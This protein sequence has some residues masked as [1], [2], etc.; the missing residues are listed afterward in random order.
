MSIHWGSLLTVFAVSLGSA[1]TV[2]ALVTLGLTGLS[3]PP[4]PRP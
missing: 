1:V 4:S 2:V 3:G